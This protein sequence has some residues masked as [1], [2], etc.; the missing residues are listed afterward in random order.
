M[1]T[2]RI[3][4]HAPNSMT[5]FSKN[6]HVSTSRTIE[7]NSDFKYNSEDSGG[8][9]LV[10]DFDLNSPHDS[11][12]FSPP[13]HKVESSLS[14]MSSLITNSNSEGDSVSTTS[15]RQSVGD[16]SDYIFGELG[17]GNWSS[18]SYH[19]DDSDGLITSY[20]PLPS[21]SRESQFESISYGCFSDMSSPVELE[22][23]FLN[24]D[25]ITKQIRKLTQHGGGGR[26]KERE[27]Y[28]PWKKAARFFMR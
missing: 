19:S 28:R 17:C 15:T 11:E 22:S 6:C 5:S 25:T 24:S 21:P 3:S 10:T 20:L 4:P 7:E 26:S 18:P 12:K 23:H 13:I 14:E 27:W 8:V 2:D 1:V 9:N 16:Y